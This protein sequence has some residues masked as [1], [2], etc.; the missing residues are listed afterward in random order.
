[1]SSVIASV[2]TKINMHDPKLSASVAH[3]QLLLPE[4]I[5]DN[6]PGH[7][8]LRPHYHMASDHFEHQ[9]M[10]TLPLALPSHEDVSEMSGHLSFLHRM[11]ELGVGMESARSSGSIF[12]DLSTH[13]SYTDLLYARGLC[14]VF[15]SDSGLL[16]L[17][18]SSYTDRFLGGSVYHNRTS[19]P[20]V[21]IKDYPEAASL[22]LPSASSRI[23]DALS[24]SPLHVSTTLAS[25]SSPSSS[26]SSPSPHRQSSVSPDSC[27]DIYSH[28][29]QNVPFSV[30]CLPLTLYEDRVPPS[31]RCSRSMNLGLSHPHPWQTP[32]SIIA[33]RPV[34]PLLSL[35]E[36]R[37]SS[38]DTRS[39][40][41]SFLE[42]YITS[43]SLLAP[44]VHRPLPFK[45]SSF[46]GVH[47]PLSSDTRRS[48]PGKELTT[49]TWKQ[50]RVRER[51]EVSAALDADREH[52][53]RLSHVKKS[54]STQTQ[55]SSFSCE[56]Q[57][58]PIYYSHDTISHDKLRTAAPLPPSYPLPPPPL[59]QYSS[60]YPPPPPLPLHHPGPSLITHSNRHLL[61][62][63]DSTSA[64]SAL[65]A[66]LS[67]PPK[68]PP[69]LPPYHSKTP[70]PQ[71]GE[72]LGSRVD[73]QHA[74]L[75]LSL[76]SAPVSKE[77]N[78]LSP[79]KRG[80]PIR[81]IDRDQNAAY[82]SVP[83]NPNG[84]HEPDEAIEEHFRR[85]LGKCYNEPSPPKQMTVHVSEKICSVDDHFARALGDQMWTE[86][87]ARSEPQ[88]D[89]GTVD[90]HFAKALGATMWKK[91]KAETKL[92]DELHSSSQ[93]LQHPTSP[94]SSLQTSLAT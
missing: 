23:S 39:S 25:S 78:K 33:S 80:S 87:K 26:L 29:R 21:V 92:V 12:T 28:R 51:Q 81:N 24:L 40:V 89:P 74:P 6:V 85:S 77:G 58:P 14:G 73:V 3:Q 11:K 72:H 43:S 65:P 93:T 79:S 15:R 62:H 2:S 8:L 10:S 13:Y 4:S 20:G 47:N 45:E 52:S 37:V 53:E 44:N 30:T 48:S 69:T 64:P 91:L 68:M 71:Y 31:E 18:L 88:I 76:S 90:A 94:T 54:A 19:A 83:T 36:P 35:Y 70:P 49:K 17:H 56:N 75:N 32:S 50:D 61:L 59:I 5:L 57:L 66:M 27:S 60:Q 9:K 55:C 67:S 16:P 22:P 63:P 82:Q 34:P 86:I 42:R 7:T 46:N 84:S 1:M 41:G 38:L